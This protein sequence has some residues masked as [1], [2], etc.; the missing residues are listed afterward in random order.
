MLLLMFKRDRRG[1]FLQAKC[2]PRRSTPFLPLA[3]FLLLLVCCAAGCLADAP[4]WKH[5]C[6]FGEMMERGPPA[7]A[8]VRDVPRRGQGAMQAYTVAAQGEESEWAPIRIK[9][10]AK[11]MDD[12]S[13][14]CTAVGDVHRLPD[15]HEEKCTEDVVLTEAKKDIVLK[16]LL[17]AAIKL[18]A[19]RLSVK[20]VRGPIRMP[21]DGI[22]RCSDFTIPPWHHTTG[23]SGADLILYVN[24][25]VQNGPVAWAIVCVTLEDGRPC[26]SAMNFNPRKIRVDH[27]SVG[28]AAHEIGH[29]LGF[30]FDRFSRFNM[31]SRI[32]NVRG[33]REVW[34]ITSPRVKAL[35]RQYYNCPTLEG[36]ELE[37]GHGGGTDLSHWE[38]L[39]A[40]DELMAPGVPYTYY[41]ALT[42]AAFE[43]SGR[44]QG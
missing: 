33:K 12:P 40:W 42:L 24:S 20:P 30:S 26:A 4:A 14:H 18:H 3:V 28:T 7:T 34:V 13:K 38:G 32:P 21:Y 27:E 39:T 1:Q 15:G 31:L 11:D 23:V 25:F 9:V 16:Q 29:A 19:E 6:G 37:D 22:G 2:R 5:R 36:M 17:P 35:A 10:S 43:D 41:S 44:V 8:V